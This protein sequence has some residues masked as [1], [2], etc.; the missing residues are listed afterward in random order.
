MN[1]IFPLLDMYFDNLTCSE[2]GRLDIVKKKNVR[3]GKNENV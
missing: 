1:C 3:Y 2:R